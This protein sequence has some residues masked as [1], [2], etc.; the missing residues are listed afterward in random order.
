DSEPNF[1]GVAFIPPGVFLRDELPSG[2]TYTILSI[3]PDPDIEG[4]PFDCTLEDAL[5]ECAVVEG[6]EVFLELAPGESISVTLAVTPDGPGQ[7]VNSS[8]GCVV[9][10]PSIE[11]PDGVILERNEGNNTC[12]DTVVVGAPDL[13]VFKA[14]DTDNATG[15]GEPF[16]WTIT[17]TNVSETTAASFGPNDLVLLDDLPTGPVYGDPIVSLGAGATSGGTF[18]CA[19]ESGTLSCGLGG[20]SSLTIEPGGFFTVTFSVAPPEAGTLLNP[21]AEGA[22]VVDPEGVTGDS[23]LTNN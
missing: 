13:A 17:I 4:L 9:D 14:N 22:C 10:P 19:I 20:E 3:D 7:L 15:V 16:N 18:D 2:A 6:E 1:D 11:L 12:G 8:A 21:P 23:N 5:L